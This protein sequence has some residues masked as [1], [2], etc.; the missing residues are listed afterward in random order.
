MAATPDHLAALALEQ[1]TDPGYPVD[2][3][4]ATVSLS[5]R[6]GADA[7]RLAAVLRGDR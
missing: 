1:R 3:G 6:Y 5:G 2:A 4:P 7:D